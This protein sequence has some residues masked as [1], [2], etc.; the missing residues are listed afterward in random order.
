[1]SFKEIVG[2]DTAIKFLKQAVSNNE[3]PPAYLFLGRDGVGKRL[4]A[5]TLSK[6]INCQKQNLDSCDECLSCKKIE[7]FNHA[8]VI[9]I[10]LSENSS[11]IKIEQIRQLKYQLSLKPFESKRKIAV[12]LDA[13][14]LN[15]E[16]SNALLKTLE[17]PPA[18]TLIILTASNASRI[19]STIISRTQVVKFF[20]LREQA[21]KQLLIK[22]HKLAEDE[23]TILSRLSQGSIGRAL[24]LK[25]NDILK[26]RDIVINNLIGQDNNFW[27]DMFAQ[28]TFKLNFLEVLDILAIWYRD[29]LI[30][31]IAGKEDELVNWDRKEDLAAF[32]QN[33]NLES[34]DKIISLIFEL[35]REAEQNLNT[36]LL[37]QRLLLEIEGVKT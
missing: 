27:E 30:L 12:I 29:L 13:D 25:D 37:C 11:F 18:D 3:L 35:R 31:K 4:T 24:Q 6:V 16:S 8:D 28:N 5:L 22:K 17:E 36:K 33:Y 23:A 26:K 32:A 34:I 10:S 14:F 21:V 7:N 19:F 20:P 2:Q 15:A 1:M 9:W